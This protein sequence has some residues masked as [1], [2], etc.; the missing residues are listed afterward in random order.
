[1][2]DRLAIGAAPSC[3]VYRCLCLD[4]L[5]L[6][7]R[8]R[9][10]HGRPEVVRI[11]YHRS[12]QPVGVVQR[13]GQVRS[14]RTSSVLPRSCLTLTPTSKSSRPATHGDDHCDH[15]GLPAPKRVAAG[16]TF[17]CAGC[18]GAYHLI[19]QWGL[20]DYYS[21]RDQLRSGEGRAVDGATAGSVNWQEL[22]EAGLLGLSVPRP[23][24]DGA[25]CSR[26]AVEGLHCGA[27]VLVD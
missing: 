2:R 15:C 4:P 21:L 22:E 17:C 27:C 24:G 6:A 12:V 9:T 26:L 3:C 13:T 1:M 14:E 11:S 18:R 16:L 19:H 20:E 25:V 5:W 7:Y 23:V 8:H 10:C